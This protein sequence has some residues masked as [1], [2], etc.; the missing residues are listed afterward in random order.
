MK[1]RIHA[2]NSRLVAI[3]LFCFLLAL[4][5]TPRGNRVGAQTSCTPLDKLSVTTAWSQNSTV[6][7]H[8]NSNEF[9]PTDYNCIKTAFA[10]WNNA[11]G[12]NLSRYFQR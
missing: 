7:V 3:L 9:S 6:T 12:A 2:S 4:I 5:F 10:N 1:L 8:V 11:K